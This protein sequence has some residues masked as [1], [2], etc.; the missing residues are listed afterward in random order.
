MLV[1]MDDVSIAAV[2]EA[3]F[4][5]FSP[6]DVIS[7]RYDAIPGVPVDEGDS[8][9]IFVNVER[10][11]AEGSTRSGSRWS[12]SKELALY[13]AHGCDHLTGASDHTAA[14]RQRMRARELRWL[15][16]AERYGLLPHCLVH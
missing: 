1:L 11:V 10:A 2:N 6:T 3:C 4:G 7:C 13:M 9:E 12:V 5:R 14:E 16:S 8:A 15:R